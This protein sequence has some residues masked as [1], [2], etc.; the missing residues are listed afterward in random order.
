MAAGSAFDAYIKSHLYK[1]VYGNFGPSDGYRLE[2]L[3]EAQVEGPLLGWGRAAGERL[4][5]AYVS[6]GALADLVRELSGAAT[7]PQ[8]EFSVKGQIG[9]AVVLG[10]PDVFFTSSSGVRVVDDFKVNGYCSRASPK[11][12]YVKIR[13]SGMMHKD[14]VLAYEGD[15]A[16][17]GV[18]YEGEW[19]DQ[20]ATYAFLMG[21]R[22]GDGW[23]FGIEQL[24]CSP[25]EIRVASHRGKVAVAY[26]EGL[27]KRYER[28][29]R[30]LQDGYMEHGKPLVEREL[31]D[32]RAEVMSDADFAALFS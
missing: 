6:C 4:F 23:L 29:W 12:G 11:P 20:M 3:L 27:V 2:S 24:A 30:I 25:K 22:V 21:E 13:P 18:P 19:A 31:L 28:L 10:K 1:T 7:P 26:Q 14:C 16:Y 17:N 9:S 5:S 15:V 32:K 8:F